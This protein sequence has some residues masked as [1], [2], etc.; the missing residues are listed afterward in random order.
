MD[1]TT[2]LLDP[3][4]VGCLLGDGG[5]AGNM[6]FAS[7]DADIIEQLNVRLAVWGYYLKKRSINP[8]RDS[9][10]TI[11]PIIK[12]TCKYQYYYKNHQ[13]K[14]TELLKIL[15]VDGYPITSHDTLH[16]VLGI[17]TKSKKSTI[18]KY[19]PQLKTDLYCVKLKETQESLLINTLNALQLRCSSTNK[20]IPEIYLQ[21]SFEDRLLLFQ[22]LMD[23]D[24]CGSGHRLE[25]CVANEGLANDFIQLATSLG[26]TCK[27][28]SKQTK[29]FNKKYNEYRSGKLAYRI[30]LNNIE[31]IEPFLCKRKLN[32]Y[33]KI[34]TEA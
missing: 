13:Y 16:S 9:E 1:K 21:A 2:L 27:K 10:Y 24:G 23:T 34:K 25:F 7:K 28:Y 19:F 18:L 29:Y 12:N 6:T 31:T 8:K 5:L 3:Y 20:R 11:T 32:T 22:G 33:K 17:S 4:I 14:A 15:Q 26:Y 30:I